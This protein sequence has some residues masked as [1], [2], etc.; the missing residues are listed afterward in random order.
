MWLNDLLRLHG[1]FADYR[2]V[3]DDAFWIRTR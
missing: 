3:G 1:A 2:C